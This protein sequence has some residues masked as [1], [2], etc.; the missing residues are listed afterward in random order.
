MFI[1]IVGKPR[2]KE[3]SLRS[4][5]KAAQFYGE[6]L[7]G[8]RLA[9]KIDL[10]IVFEKFKKGSNDYA[11]CDW[12]D[13]NHCPREF[14]VTIDANLS[15]RETFE[16]LAH[17]LVHCKQYAK[18]ELKDIFRPVRMVKWQGVKYNIDEE[19]YWELPF[20]IEAYGREKGLYIKFLQ[21]LRTMPGDDAI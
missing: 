16:A 1:K 5:K 7:M 3:V 17:E 12:I 6:Y 4:V 19:D 8:S 13:D 15:K 2:K 14:V 18:G 20:E 21:Y 11:Y 9:S 10:K